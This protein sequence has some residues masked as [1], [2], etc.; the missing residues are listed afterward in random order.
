MR[1]VPRMAAC[2]QSIT[3]G[4]RR[5]R[6]SRRLSWAL[7]TSALRTLAARRCSQTSTLASTW[8]RASPSS[9]PMV[10]SC[11]QQVHLRCAHSSCEPALVSSQHTVMSWKAQMTLESYCFEQLMHRRHWQV[12]AAE[13]DCGRAGAHKGPDLTQPQGAYVPHLL[14]E[15]AEVGTWGAVKGSEV[16]RRV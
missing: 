10:R 2:A 11:S 5:L 16:R 1:S 12:D 3:S 9:G 15:T 14:A 7:W 13:S 4:S 8:S 6:P